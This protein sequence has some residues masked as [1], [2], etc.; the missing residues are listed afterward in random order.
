MIPTDITSAVQ[1]YVQ[2]QSGGAV[3]EP[4]NGSWIQAYCEYLGSGT[5]VGTS[6]VQTLCFHFGV[7]SPSNGSWVQALAEYYGLTQPLNNSWWYALAD[8]GAGPAP[9]LVWNTTTTLWELET[10]AWNA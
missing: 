2:T 5:R 8:M 4:S 10:T 1:V 3:T 9:S 7:T 6:W